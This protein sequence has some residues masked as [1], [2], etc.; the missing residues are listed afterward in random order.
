M[1][2]MKSYIGRFLNQETTRP[3]NIADQQL[4][5][6]KILDTEAN[7]ADNYF[8][9]RYWTKPNFDGTQTVT[10]LLGD[11]PEAAIGAGFGY[12]EGS[13]YT[14]Q[15]LD[16]TKKRQTLIFPDTAELWAFS[17][18]YETGTD[19]RAELSN[20]KPVELE[21]SESPLVI[22]VID[23]A[24]AKFTPIRSK[25]AEI[26]C[27]SSDTIDMDDFTEGG[28]TRFIVE[29]DMPYTS[30]AL[31]RGFLSVSDMSQEF[32]PDPNVIVLTATDGLGFLNDERLVD[33]DGKN[34]TNDRVIMDY[35][36]WALARTGQ[37]LE[38]D[39]IMNVRDPE[40][41]TLD[42]VDGG[43]GHFYKWFYLD[44][45][46]FEDDI[47]ESLDCYEVLLQIL[48][49]MCFI[50]QYQGRWRIQRIDEM[51]I[52]AEL[53]IFRFNS[54]GGFI[55]REQYNPEKSIGRG[56]P[57][58]W[59][60]DDAVK[61]AQRAN[62]E[63][64]LNFQYNFPQ[65]LICNIDLSRGEGVTPDEDFT[66][67]IDLIPECIEY[68]REGS[69]VNI[70]TL[71]QP[72]S[73]GATGVLRREF[74]G[75]QE[76]ANYLLGH[77]AGGFRHYFKFEPLVVGENDKIEFGFS[78]KLLSPSVVTN[79]YPLLVI[80]EGNDG[81]FWLW[82]YDQPT[83]ASNWV[84]KTAADSPFFDLWR[85]DLT[86]AIPS[87]W[88]SISATSK[89]MPVAGK[90]YFRFLVTNADYDFAFADLNLRYIVYINGSYPSYTGQRNSVTNSNLDSKALLD[91]QVFMSDG[92][93][94]AMKG[95]LKVPTVEG[96]KLGSLVYDAARSPG[97]VLNPMRFGK[98]QI[99]DVWNQYRRVMMQFEGVV[100]GLE[101]AVEIPDIVN[102]YIL[103]DPDKSTMNRIFMVLHYEQDHHLC[104]FTLFLQELHDSTKPKVY[105][106]H[107][108]KY[109]TTDE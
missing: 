84:Q 44:A 2:N 29:I 104:E 74:E 4:V 70:G 80:L 24:E 88:Q 19:Y 93:A 61:S 20:V 75:G 3:D 96:Y 106:G 53:N 12:T 71:D 72:P 60:N 45:K 35:I 66:G 101:S 103:T 6:I 48:G 14:E 18:D 97:A 9:T 69:P 23:N 102:T 36:V 62:K 85:A 46:T 68:L 42:T 90:I 7:V 98:F 25:Q 89:P 21:L 43:Q 87:D 50:T 73:V 94:L 40:A 83:G 91:E 38:I 41:P 109:I 10:V 32:Q 28:D 67:A 55:V 8:N 99:Y 22:S 30:N 65:E 92:P 16:I 13:D 107:Q 59:M 57:L 51:E 86:G 34:P 82:N 58:S 26:R 56:L 79:I 52:G 49:Y 76:Q 5:E 105:E 33:F 78:F 17:V 54:S 63:V 81:S 1:T 31:F 100:D 95:V 47:G 27:Y 108:F 15:P 77:L 64:R 11:L 39:I 37:L